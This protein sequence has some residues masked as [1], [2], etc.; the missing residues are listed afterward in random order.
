MATEKIIC[1][2]VLER[3]GQ[4]MPHRITCEAPGLVKRQGDGGENM[5]RRLLV[6]SIGKNW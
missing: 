6:V 5:G 1:Y 3:R 4:P 2:L